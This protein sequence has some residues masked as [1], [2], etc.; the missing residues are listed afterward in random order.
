MDS[1]LSNQ[2]RRKAATFFEIL[3]QNFWFWAPTLAASIY[4][5]KVIFKARRV[6]NRKDSNKKI[7]GVTISKS[8]SIL[9]LASP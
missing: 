6:R 2:N 9:K 3:H 7:L 4:T 8:P 1:V 5:L